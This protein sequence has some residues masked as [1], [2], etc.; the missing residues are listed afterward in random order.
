MTDDPAEKTSF[1][2]NPRIDCILAFYDWFC[3]PVGSSYRKHEFWDVCESGDKTE[4]LAWLKTAWK[5]GYECGISKEA[6]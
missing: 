3:E 5:L 1:A 2:P 6:Q 4:L